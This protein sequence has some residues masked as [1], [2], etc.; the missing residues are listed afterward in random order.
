[1]TP[2]P[3]DVSL[4]IICRDG[5][6]RHGSGGAR[7]AHL[8]L[9]QEMLALHLAPVLHYCQTGVV[10]IER[11]GGRTSQRLGL[12]LHKVVRGIAEEESKGHALIWTNDIQ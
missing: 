12:V 10:I 4:G 1:M 9:N 8:T 5:K 11:Q 3:N 2:Q 7:V 6:P